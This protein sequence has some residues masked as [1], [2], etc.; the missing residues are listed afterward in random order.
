MFVL[1]P[2]TALIIA[3][4]SVYT[5]RFSMRPGSEPTPAITLDGVLPVKVFAASKDELPVATHVRRSA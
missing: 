4:G 2:L 5:S 3:N 1:Q